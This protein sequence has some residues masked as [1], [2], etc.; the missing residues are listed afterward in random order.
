MRD[1]VGD[2]LA[3]A[4]HNVDGAPGPFL[5]QSLFGSGLAP[6]SVARLGQ[7]ARRLW[8]QAFD[9]MAAEAGPLLDA[10]TRG[11]DGSMRMRFGVY[12]YA[13][14]LD[15]ADA[16]PRRPAGPASAPS[17]SSDASASSAASPPSS[18]STRRSS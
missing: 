11:P 17:P 10:D 4:A 2:H 14:P 9:Q 8:K 16:A 6:R 18:S 3:A 1:N 15:E 13:E 12:F 7:L 5:E